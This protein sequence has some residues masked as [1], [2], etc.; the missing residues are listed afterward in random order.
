M[1]TPRVRDF[2]PNAKVPALK[3]SMDNMPTI[4]RPKINPPAPLSTQTQ[5][6]IH[7]F[8]KAKIYKTDV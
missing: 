6:I 8:R 2:D 3:S 5:N 1:K 4:G 7:K